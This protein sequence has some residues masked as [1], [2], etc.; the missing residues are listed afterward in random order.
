MVLVSLDHDHPVALRGKALRQQ[1]ALAAQPAD[2]HVVA[3]EAQ[4]ELLPAVA[5]KG[6]QRADRGPGR[7]QGDEEAPGLQ[8]PAHRPLHR[9]GVHGDELEGEVGPVEQA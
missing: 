5:E 7:E 6:Q 1:P 2:D 9:A 8:L 3:P 4:E